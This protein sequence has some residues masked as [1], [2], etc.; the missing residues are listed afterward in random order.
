MAPFPA[1]RNLGLGP[2]GTRATTR[3]VEA[4]TLVS[5]APFARVTHRRPAL[6]KGLNDPAGTCTTGRTVPT[7]GSIRISEGDRSTSQPLPEPVVMPP[8]AAIGPTLYVATSA[9][10]LKSTR[11]RP[12][13]RPHRGT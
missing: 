7:D 5:S 13:D 6:K 11:A 3:P 4:S 12:P 9:L 2:V 10:V 1:L 8:S